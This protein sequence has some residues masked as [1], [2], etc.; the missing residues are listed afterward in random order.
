MHAH[1]PEV[2]IARNIDPRPRKIAV[3]HMGI[4]PLAGCQDWVTAHN[5]IW[6]LRSRFA[7]VEKTGAEIRIHPSS[8]IRCRI[9]PEVHFLHQGDIGFEALENPVSMA[10][11][12]GLPRAAG[13]VCRHNANDL[14]CAGRAG[15]AYAEKK[16]Q[17]DPLPRYAAPA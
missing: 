3:A 5:T 7:I 14:I 17:D 6:N 11:V 9:V 1:C 16:G 8:Q 13:G 10:R 12:V 4:V 15:K 2:F